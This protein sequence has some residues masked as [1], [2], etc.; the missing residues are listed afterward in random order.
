[1][2][3]ENYSI[4]F[5]SLT[6]NT[7]KLAD[8]IHETLPKNECDYFGAI[9]A[10]VP[11]SKLLYVGFWTDKGNADHKT[12]ELL[13]KLKNKKVWKK[14]LESKFCCYYF[15]YKHMFRL[16]K[17]EILYRILQM[18]TLKNRKKEGKNV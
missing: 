12:F 14:Y 3:R 7:K 16:N 6:G 4:V 1:M 11:Q 18:C 15:D 17:R 10:Q 2:K 13:S 8:V 9:E 5:S